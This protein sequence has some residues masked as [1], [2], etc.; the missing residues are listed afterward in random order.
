ML[1]EVFT[2]PGAF[3]TPDVQTAYSIAAGTNLK[4]ET[5]QSNETSNFTQSK[6]TISHTQ[7][8]KNQSIK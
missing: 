2:I 4:N 6:V 5:T 7:S 8:N 3:A 1:R